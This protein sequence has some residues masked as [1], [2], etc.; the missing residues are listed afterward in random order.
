MSDAKFEILPGLS[1][2]GSPAIPFPAAN[3][4]FSE[5]FVVRFIPS[6]SEEWTGN[7]RCGDTRYSNVHM[8][9]DAKRIFVVAGG[10]DYLIDPNTKSA[11]GHATQDISFSH[12]IPE[13]NIV[14]F[15][16]YIRF[17]AEDKDGRKWTTPRLSWD[18]IRVI[19]PP[20]Q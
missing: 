5:G 4:G 16:N 18:G 6:P 20:C 8:H 15:G 3:R 19:S 1:G 7:F 2:S 10:A 9:P 14:I 13:L 17:W 12:D 11:E